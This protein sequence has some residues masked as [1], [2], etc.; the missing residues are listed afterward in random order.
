MSTTSK[1]W[2]DLAMRL[3]CTAIIVLG[4]MMIPAFIASVLMSLKPEKFTV[5]QVDLAFVVWLSLAVGIALLFWIAQNCEDSAT[6]ERIQEMNRR[7]M[8]RDIQT[9][10]DIKP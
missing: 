3:R 9:S 2:R 4:T 7:R 10:T 5:N 6:E 8:T 1:E